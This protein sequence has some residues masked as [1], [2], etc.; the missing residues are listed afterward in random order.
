MT[1][2]KFD[3]VC[4]ETGK[5]IKKGQNCLYYPSDKSVYHPE[6]KQAYEWRNMK[7]DEAQGYSY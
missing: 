3:T 5:P 7:A 6:S 4:K 2:S 1:V